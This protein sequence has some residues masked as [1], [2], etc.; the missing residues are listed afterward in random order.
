[1][2]FKIEKDIFLRGLQK[3][4]GII[5]KKTSMP[6]L[7]NILIETTNEQIE[8]TATDLEVALTASYPAKVLS[9]GKITISGKKLFEIIKELPDDEVHLLTKENDW[10]EIKCQKVK[11][12]IVGLPSEDFPKND[13]KLNSNLVEIEASILRDM[14]EKTSYSICNDESKYNLN[15]VFTTV[16]TVNDIQHLK[17]VSTD[18][19]RLSIVLNKLHNKVSQELI[20]GVILPKK[21][22]YEIK[23]ITEEGDALLKFGFIDNNAIVKKNDVILSMRLVNG[24]F[25]DYSR[26]IPVSNDLIVKINREQL[27]QSVR[28]MSILS[29]EKVKGITLEIKNNAMCISSSNPE[30]GDAVEEL[31]IEYSGEVFS[32]RFNARYLMDVLMVCSTENILMKFK[33]EVSPSVIIPDNNDENLLAVIMPMRL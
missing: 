22:I 33:N 27:L 17:M 25:P 18:G 31:D 19:H 30:L 29:N 21:G 14:I 13:I 6:I 20:D 23:K 3:V 5:E 11:F 10:I 15:G 16:E 28:R 1:M 8:I 2:E 4:Q 9:Q 24:E 12:N 32:V 7:A 26:V